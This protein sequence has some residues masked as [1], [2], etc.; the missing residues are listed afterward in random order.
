MYNYVQAR[1]LTQT[2][3]GARVSETLERIWEGLD[4]EKQVPAKNAIAEIWKMLDGFRK[5]GDKAPE[6][7]TNP[8]NEELTRREQELS[9]R[10][11]KALISP[12]ANEGRR[13]IETIVE[14]D[15][16]KS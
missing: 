6:R 3:D 5:V 1:V 2:L 4:A 7:K 16:P 8:Q 12:I 10:E 9:A 14:R 15:A 11:A 13:Q